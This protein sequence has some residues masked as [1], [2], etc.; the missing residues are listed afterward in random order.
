MTTLCRTYPSVLVA[1]RA[2][3]ELRSAG[4]P[5]RDIR[6]LEG[7]RIHDLRQEPTGCFDK[8][9]PPDAPVGTYAGFR[10]PRHRRVGSFANGASAR[11]HGSFADTD[12]DLIVTYE[13]GAERAM[14]TDPSLRRLLEGAVGPPAVD[15]VVDELHSGHAAVLAEVAEVRAREARERLDRVARA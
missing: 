5:E 11:R 4:V 7:A 10:H 1:R 2:V 14:T 12:G 13:D 8:T 9:E 15:R 3:D 6:M